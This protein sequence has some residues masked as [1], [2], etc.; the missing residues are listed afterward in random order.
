[1]KVELQQLLAPVRSEPSREK[2]LDALLAGEGLLLRTNILLPWYRWR[3]SASFPKELEG[4]RI[5]SFGWVDY[6][7]LWFRS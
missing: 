6:K 2:R 7:E 1:M 3:Q 4:V 5:S